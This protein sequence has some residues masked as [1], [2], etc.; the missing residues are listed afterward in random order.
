LISLAEVSDQK[1][2]NLALSPQDQTKTLLMNATNDIVAAGN[3]EKQDAADVIGRDS[4][5]TGDSSLDCRVVTFNPSATA[6]PHDKRVDFGTGCTGS[7][8]IMRKGKK[9]ITIY[10]N[11]ET[12]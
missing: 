12:A 6:Y 3:E 5:K 2:D 1:N 9:M 11:T 8:G 4:S 10:A 7:D